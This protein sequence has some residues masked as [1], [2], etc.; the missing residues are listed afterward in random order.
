[1]SNNHDF[2]TKLMENKEYVNCDK[3]TRM[4]M[5][6]ILQDSD[7]IKDAL[8]Y[9]IDFAKQ[10]FSEIKGFKDYNAAATF[11]NI[12]ESTPQL[13]SSEEVYKN[14]YEKLLNPHLKGRYTTLRKRSSYKK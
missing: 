6:A 8:I 9:G 14:T 1:M 11:I 7:C 2:L 13:L 12:I 3:D 4:C 10:Y 5:S